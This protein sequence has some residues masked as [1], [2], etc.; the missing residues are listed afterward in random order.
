[1]VSQHR[2]GRERGVGMVQG[3]KLR[4][5]QKRVAQ[6]AVEPLGEG[7]LRARLFCVSA[8]DIAA[9]HAEYATSRRIAQEANQQ[10]KTIK[11]KLQTATGK[12]FS[13]EG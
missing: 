5:V 11:A 8:D 3:R 6:A 12:E 7:D 9:V 4:L 1:V 13:P 2:P 10:R